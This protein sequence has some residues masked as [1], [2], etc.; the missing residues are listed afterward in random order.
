MRIERLWVEHL[1]LRLRRRKMARLTRRR[2]RT[3]KR[4]KNENGAAMILMRKRPRRRSKPMTLLLTLLWLFRR[5]SLRFRRHRARAIAAKNRAG[6]SSA[7]MSEILGI[8]SQSTTPTPGT[9]T[10]ITKLDEPPTM[11]KLTVSTKSVAD[12]FKERL[13]AKQ[14]ARRQCQARPRAVRTRMRPPVAALGRLDLRFD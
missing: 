3:R 12:Y 8:S 10:P 7:A 11:E 14:M 5:L 6:N 4:I 1:Y 13:L 2:R 9:C